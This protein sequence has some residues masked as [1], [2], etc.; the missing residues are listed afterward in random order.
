ME[1]EPESNWLMEIQGPGPGLTGLPLLS[2]GHRWLTF[3][4]SK[5]YKKEKF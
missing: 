2:S 5:L 4:D 1:S 3:H